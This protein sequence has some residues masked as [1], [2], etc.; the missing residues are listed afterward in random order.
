ME[1]ESGSPQERLRQIAEM[2]GEPIETFSR[3]VYDHGGSLYANIPARASNMWDVDS[4]E[5]ISVEVHDDRLVIRPEI[6]E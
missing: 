2:R 3:S 6:N 1:S 4:G 5:E